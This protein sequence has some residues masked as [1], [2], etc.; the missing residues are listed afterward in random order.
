MNVYIKDS[1]QPAEACVIWLHGLGAD[2]RDMMGAA[3]QLPLSASIRHV[4]LDAPMR[5]VTLNNGIAMRAW[6]D[7]LSLDNQT[8]EDRAGILA[9]AERIQET[10]MAQNVQGMQTQRI[11]LAGFSQGGALALYTALQSGLPL[12]GVIS[13]SSYLPLAHE[14]VVHSAPRL[15]IFLAMGQYDQIVAPAWTRKTYQWLRDH[16]MQQI[17]WH[18]Y[19]MEHTICMQ[20]LRDLGAW[21]N[22]RMMTLSKNEA[23]I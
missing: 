10:I 11:F 17:A 14:C 9:S 22:Q 5:P 8:S 19:P 3:E 20:E 4:F 13:L 21:I 7:I 2:G 1:N 23:S 15:P 6:Y 12:A 18:E 16:E